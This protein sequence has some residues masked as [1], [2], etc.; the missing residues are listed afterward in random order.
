MPSEKTNEF[1]PAISKL[2]NHLY[3]SAKNFPSH[4]TNYP[5]QFGPNE[6]T[7]DNPFLSPFVRKEVEIIPLLPDEGGKKNIPSFN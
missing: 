5:A 1:Y 3:I 2:F 6:G 7:H 4:F